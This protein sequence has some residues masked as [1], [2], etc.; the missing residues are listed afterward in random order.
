MSRALIAALEKLVA[1]GTDVPASALTAAQRATLNEF[2]RKTGAVRTKPQGSGLV[3]QIANLPLLQEHLKSLRPHNAD[4]LLDSLPTRAANIAQTRNSKGKGH[5]HGHYYLLIKPIGSNVIWHHEDG[6]KL[7]LS[8][9]SA[10]AGAGALAI[11][12]NDAWYTEQPLWLVENQALF[13]RLDWLPP[14]AKGT[15]TYYGGQIHGQLLKWLAARQRTPQMV[16]FPDYDGVGLLN[17]AKLLET[18][19]CPCTFWLIPDWKNLLQKYGNNSVWQNTLSDF[20][21]ALPR[22]QAARMNDEVQELC[23]SLSTIGLAL[24]HEV[25]WLSELSRSHI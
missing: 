14:E 21:A 19:C 25:I 13:N 3:Y 9:V 16:F 22:L 11:Q 2:E 12:A 8:A 18:A 23:V 5:S 6:R 10:I 7:D 17:Y 15:I 1:S 24:E 20:H 4:D